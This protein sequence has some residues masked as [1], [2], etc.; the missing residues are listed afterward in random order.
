VQDLLAVSFRVHGDDLDARYQAV[1][2]VTSEWA[3]RGPG[4]P[5][6]F[7]DEPTGERPDVNGYRLDW[8][9]YAPRGRSESSLTVVLR[10]P[11]DQTAGREWRTVIDITRLSD[12]VGV[13]VRLAREAVEFRMVPAAL[14]SLRRP[15]LVP[16][17][18]NSFP[19]TAGGFDLT[20]TAS[21]VHVTGVADFVHDFLRSP[22]RVLPVVVISP[23]SERPGERAP[24][25]VA[26][27]LAG[28]AH[29][30]VLGGHL[31][32]KR[33]RDVAGDDFRIPPGG[34][35]LFWPGFGARD[36]HLRHRYWTH[37]VLTEDPVSADRMLFGILSRVSVHAVPRDP[38]PAELRHTLAEQRLHDLAAEGKS[39]AELLA[40]YADEREELAEEVKELRALTQDQARQIAAHEQNW[41]ALG[42]SRYIADAEQAGELDEDVPF[43]PGSWR[44]FA[45]HLP[46]LESPAFAITPRAKE[47]CDPSPYPD[48]ARMWSH[49]ARLAEAAD[50]WAA[51]NCA[52]GN[53]LKTWI[54]ENFDG[55]EISLHD[56]GLG[57]R[58]SF[59]FEGETYSREPHVKVDDY[60]GPDE[61]GRIYFAMDR[62]EQRFIVDHIGL[63]L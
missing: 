12:H 2:V 26:D 37:R 17:L 42:G 8:E 18:L 46:L 22:D 48:P 60:K 16:E 29:V 53:A 20:A 5:P 34:L 63:H 47:G 9:E 30:F 56:R 25:K 49:L 10:H 36:D 58:A 11:D 52:V 3:W 31:A 14:A 35:R 44:E 23:S 38:L 59:S 32:M 41:E 40:L 61:C 39:D 28:L 4:S 27:E 21:S 62:D 51:Q 43:V 13:T 57:S 54:Q 15:G 33:F 50:A 1:G 55:L 6:S 7:V 45:E 24:D 19:C